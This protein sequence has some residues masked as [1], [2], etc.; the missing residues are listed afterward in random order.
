MKK[1]LIATTALVATA[2]VAAAE[3]TLS[4][5]A[6]MGVVYDGGNYLN[7]LGDD[8]ATLNFN[9]RV[10]VK[11]TL[12]GETDGGLQFGGSFRTHQAIGAANGV[13]GEVYISGAFGRLAMGDTVGAAEELIGD[14]PEIGYSDVASFGGGDNDIGYI[15]GDNNGN[16]IL[17]TGNT[18]PNALYTYSTGALKFALSMN[19]GRTTFGT[20]TLGSAQDYALGA[21][22]TMDAYTVALAYEVSDPAVGNSAKHLILGGDATFGD[23]VVKAFYGDGSGTLN[24]FTQYG[25]GV[26]SKFDAITVKAFIRK[27]EVDLGSAANVNHFAAG[28][29]T[30][31][32]LGG[33]YSL[34]G[35]A[36]VAG[37]LTDNDFAGSKVRGDLGI[38]FAF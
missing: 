34:G 36:T 33:E 21:S 17:A 37:G 35:G 27:D 23:T 10:R 18:G 31:W 19:D 13:N 15:T 6:R 12:S 2:G 4:G 24:G 16:L 22:Y 29:V 32:G 28:K 20:T 1:F 30:T 14:L 26:T 9:S 8:K 7:H 5:D 38:K 3:V 25:L 11:F